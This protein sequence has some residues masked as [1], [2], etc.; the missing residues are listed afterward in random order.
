M[1]ISN[2]AELIPFF[3]RLLKNI[4]HMNLMTLQMLL[5]M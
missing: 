4:V 3:Y 2:M 1:T 5:P